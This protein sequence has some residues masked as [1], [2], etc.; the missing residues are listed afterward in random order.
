MHPFIKLALLIS[1]VLV[2]VAIFIHI[3]PW[4]IAILAILAVIKLYHWLRQPRDNRTLPRW[5]WRDP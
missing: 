1:A 4:I 5:P 3:L 2:A